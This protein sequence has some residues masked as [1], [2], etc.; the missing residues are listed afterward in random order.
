[1]PLAIVGA[2]LLVFAQGGGLDIFGMM[3][4][5]ML[6]GLSAK[7]AILYLD[8]VVERI[9]R[10]PFTEA[11]VEA[12]RLRFRPIIMTTMT[13]LVIS[14]P[15]I[16]G[17]GE[18]SEF[19]KN[20]GVVMLGGILFSA[21]LTFFVVPAAFY[22]F[23]RKRVDRTEG[24]SVP[25]QQ[26]QLGK[27]LEALEVPM[28]LGANASTIY[29]VLL[30]DK[31]DG[32]TLID[33]GVPG[34]EKAIEEHLQR[35]GLGW[36]DIRRIIITHQ[37]IDHIGGASAAVKASNAEV[38]AHR[39]D[40]PYI[41]GERRLLKADPDRIEKMVQNVPEERREAVRR[42]FS[43][44]PKVHVT[45]ALADGEKLPYGG[46]I[47]VIHTPGHT[48]GHISLYL[49][50]DRLLISGD[51]L[52]AENGVLQGPSPGATADLALA[53]ASLRKL[54]DYPIDR[55]LCYH[56]GLANRGA[57]ARLRELAGAV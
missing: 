15:L 10:M 3:G 9:G 19:G 18:G 21:V 52:R 17:K 30:W 1:V 56:G 39:D 33:T 6:I 29:P 2:L 23:E 20:M 5:L 41:Q 14:F 24:A 8:F 53:T 36:K 40:I 11:L 13:V 54:L 50:A 51:A 25:F 42:I 12:G 38:L 34:S 7:N 27:N 31:K 35:L 46:G 57:L 16:L 45:R 4:M 43:D 49:E 55:V 47:V 48:P 28:R 22:L 44:P 32:A 37:D 26:M